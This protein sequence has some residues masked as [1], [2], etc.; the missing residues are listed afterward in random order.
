MDPTNINMD[1]LIAAIAGFA[2]GAILVGIISRSGRK[3]KDDDAEAKERA[4]Q[5]EFDAYRE[6]VNTHFAQT[7]NAVDELTKSYKQVFEHL[8]HGAQDL[9]DEK[10]LQAQLEKRQNKAVTLA[11][12]VEQNDAPTSPD[13]ARTAKPAAPESTA[14]ASKT[15]PKPADK[16]PVTDKPVEKKPVVDKPRAAFVA[17]NASRTTPT[18]GEKT[19]K[20]AA[21]D[22]TTDP[23]KAKPA[24]PAATPTPASEATPAPAKPAAARPADEKSNV[25]KAAEKAGLKRSGDSDNK[26]NIIENNEH[27]TAIE[28]IKKHI[29]QDDKK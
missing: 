26:T 13:E 18:S 19:A 16:K 10:A 20:P 1:V 29:K 5:Q 9:M 24:T 15:P 2:I 11:Y 23:V 21:A 28:S 14:S 22:K 27:E 7:A 17:D 25:H 12:L 6:K 8:S 3:H 4:L